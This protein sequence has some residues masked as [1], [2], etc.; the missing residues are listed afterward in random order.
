MGP[1]DDLPG[2]EGN[3][4]YPAVSGLVYLPTKEG[5]SYKIK[6]VYPDVST[7]LCFKCIDS[8][9]PQE[10]REVLEKVYASYRTE[11]F[12][13]AYQE[14]ERGKLVD[15]KESKWSEFYDRF[16]DGLSK[17]E[18]DCLFCGDN[19][20]NG[21]PFFIG[22]VIDKVSS[23]KNLTFGVN[24]SCS[25]MKMGSTF[26]RICFDD[27]RKNFPRV[28]ENLSFS[29][30][31]EKNLNFSTKQNEIY[32]DKELEEAYERETGKK[33]DEVVRA[34]IQGSDNLLI[35]RESKDE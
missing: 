10:R 30:S 12:F 13:K 16:K 25:N 6:Y 4:V 34:L 24:Y 27:L 21:N 7:S 19:I 20:E 35:V 3:L 8:K 29:L 18:K 2:R 9:V 33:F 31:G 15:C 5:I 22:R 17:L 32:I 11:T 23:S 28:F 14:S 26:F 1:S